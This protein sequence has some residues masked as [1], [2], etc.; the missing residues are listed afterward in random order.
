VVATEEEASPEDVS[1]EVATEEVENLEEA[2]LEEVCSEVAS[3]EEVSLEVATQE[4]KS[5][6]VVDLGKAIQSEYC[7]MA[8]S[9][10]RTEPIEVLYSSGLDVLYKIYLN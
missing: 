10:L 3:L 2:S 5:Q 6:E 1:L 9:V 8:R 7:G 4:V